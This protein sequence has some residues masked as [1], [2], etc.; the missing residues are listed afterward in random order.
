MLREE[1]LK[2]FK[3]PR[4]MASY[5]LE[6]RNDVNNESFTSVNVNDG[7]YEKDIRF[8][9]QA[10]NYDKIHEHR[11]NEYALHLE[12]LLSQK[13]EVYQEPIAVQENQKISDE[14]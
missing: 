4:K 3:D 13:A 8:L 14:V 5:K 10:E 1:E 11:L 7:M 2:I 6:M 12:N 9:K